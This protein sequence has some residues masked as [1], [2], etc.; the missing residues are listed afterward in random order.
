M[1]KETRKNR[2]ILVETLR[3]DR[4]KIQNIDFHNDRMNRARRDLYFLSDSID[5]RE[6]IVLVPKGTHRCRVIYNDHVL[7]IHYLPPVEKIRKSFRFVNAD[8]EYRYKY[9]DR[10]HIEKLLT[11]KGVSDDILIVR[12]GLLTDASSS[13]IAFFHNNQWIT[14]AIPLLEGTTRQRYLEAGKLR[15]ADITP[16][17]AAK[18]EKMALMNAIID[19]EIIENPLFTR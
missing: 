17:K 2:P 1:I 11:A 12:N 15:A 10:E 14:P 13:N 16:G 18:C 19:F 9:L 4:G 6:I 7:R 5:L 8:I 3:I